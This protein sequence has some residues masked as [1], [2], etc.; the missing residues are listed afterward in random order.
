M[1]F[2]ITIPAYK[3]TYLK[4]C[5]DSILAQTYDDFEIVIVDDCSPE[6]LKAIVDK[7]NDKR[8]RYYRNEQNYGAL[9]VVDNWNK[10]LEYA[11]GDYIICMGDDDRLLPI[12]LEEY[13]KLIEKYPDL[14]VYHGW[15][16][17]V[18]EETTFVT[19]QYPR[20]IWESVYGLIWGRWTYRNDQYIGD[21]VFETKSLRKEGGFYKLPM[22]W[23]SDDIT[24]VRAAVDGGIANTQSPCFQYRRNS[25]SITATA[26]AEMKL[27]AIQLEKEWYQYLLKKSPIDEM[28]K[29]LYSLIMER[30]PRYFMNKKGTLVG[31]DIMQ[32][33]ITRIPFWICNKSQ[34]HL[35]LTQIIRGY[36]KVCLHHINR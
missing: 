8:I 25:Y 24:A 21:F 16:E 2:S 26:D 1:K 35:S 14:K 7:Y 32:N 22:A 36:L 23:G 15:T 33:G 10:C 11:K 34:F 3:K 6:D 4:E 18:D 30:M 9:N 17:I 20:P 13:C 12:C 5:I 19:F 28:D 31:Q 27:K 29:K